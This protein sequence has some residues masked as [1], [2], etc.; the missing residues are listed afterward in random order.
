MS[1]PL[2]PA[3]FQAA[4]ALAGSEAIQK[5][6][7]DVINW[8]GIGVG[9]GA[10]GAGV[11]HTGRA[12]NR[13]LAGPGSSYSGDRKGPVYVAHKLANQP[14]VP[15]IAAPAP[16]D[17]MFKHTAPALAL[18]AGLPL[19]YSV[20][21]A[22]MSRV[23][24]MRRNRE[25]QD[26]QAEFEQELQAYAATKGL[27]QRTRK[28]ATI[29]NVKMRQ[30]VENL[31]ELTSKTASV[32]EIVKAIIG[33]GAGVGALSFGAGF[34]NQHGSGAPQAL[35]IAEARL[36]QGREAVNPSGF[37]LHTENIGKPLQSGQLSES[38]RKQQ[39][40]QRLVDDALDDVDTTYVQ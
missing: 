40:R 17:G 20:V 34:Y 28:R 10:A 12:I 25:L 4:N 30:L 1:Q 38:E 24:G 22:L 33:A 15:S 8:L 37:Y 19:G 26:A 32:K 18:A 27:N 29:E 3:D 9:V 13:T 16:D 39:L 14:V 7:K 5:K 21:N 6:W 11:L 31:V 36:Q 35:R 23:G 2:S